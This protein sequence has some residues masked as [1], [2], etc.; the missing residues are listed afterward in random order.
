M[1]R[2]LNACILNNG[3]GVKVKASQEEPRQ[4]VSADSRHSGTDGRELPLDKKKGKSVFRIFFKLVVRSM[5][6]SPLPPI[7]LPP[8]ATAVKVRKIWILFSWGFC[9]TTILGSSYFIMLYGLK[10]GPVKSQEWLSTVLVSS[11]GDMFLS[12]PGKII[13]FSIILAITSQR[14]YEVNTHGVDY[15]QALLVKFPHGEEYMRDLLIKRSHPMYIPISQEKRQEILQKKELKDNWMSTGDFTASLFFV[16]LISTLISRMWSSHYYTN[17]QIKKLVTSSHHPDVGAIDFFSIYDN[18]DMERYLEYTLIFALYNT[19]WYNGNDIERGNYSHGIEYWTSDCTNKQLGL[20]KLRQLRTKPRICRNTLN[21]EENCMPKLSEEDKDTDVYGVA[22]TPSS[23]LDVTRNNS[24]WKYTD[25]DSSLTFE[26]FR[27]RDDNEPE[28]P[29]KRRIVVKQVRYKCEVIK[30]ARLKG[31]S[32]TNWKV[33]DV[34]RRTQVSA[35]NPKPRAHSYTFRVSC[36]TG[37]YPVCKKAFIAM[38]G[39]TA[40]R[41]RRLYNI[42]STGKSPVDFGVKTALD[43]IFVTCEE[44]GVKIKSRRLNDVTKRAAIAEKIVHLKRNKKF[45]TK[46]KEVLDFVKD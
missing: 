41:V 4:A 42:L 16:V 44:L 17:T 30:E 24:P 5:K 31:E 26:L 32:Y 8:T 36:S 38:H 43:D 35:T 45:S 22:W 20:P 6:T 19:K 34:E 3:V 11:G 1:R 9:I 23:S 27:L 33:H 13:L 12:D 2:R 10:L 25:V 21:Q 15:V 7:Q 18:K 14:M 28:V 29:V 40:M 37:S 39:K 46:M